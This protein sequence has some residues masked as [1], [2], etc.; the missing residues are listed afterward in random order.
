M[1]DGVPGTL[2]IGI[3]R[4]GDAGGLGAASEAG[5]IAA[6]FIPKKFGTTEVV[7]GRQALKDS[8]NADIPVSAWERILLNIIPQYGNIDGNETIDLRDAILTLQFVTKTPA[9]PI[10]Y[11]EGAVQVY[12]KI[13]VETAVY[14][15]QVL[16]EMRN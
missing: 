13:G 10:V 6:S 4:V 15:L 16:G 11:P 2:V 7:F 9:A 3:T 14:V 5:V 12:G 8:D 1:E